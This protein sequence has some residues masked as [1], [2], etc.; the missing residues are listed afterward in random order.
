MKRSNILKLGMVAFLSLGLT[1]CFIS[2]QEEADVALAKWQGKKINDFFFAYGKGEF[3][4]QSSGGAKAYRWKSA[5]RRV[6]I[7]GVSYAVRVED[8][9]IP[10]RFYEKVVYA[11]SSYRNYQ[12]VL[13]IETSAGGVIRSL[14][15]VNGTGECARYFSLSKAEI[16]ALLEARK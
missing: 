5:S 16:D 1:S 11:P 6:E 12:C 2:D 3:Q 15:N 8:S 13:R 10:G 4:A 14:N 9:Y 7:V